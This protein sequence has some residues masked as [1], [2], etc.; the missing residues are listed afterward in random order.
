VIQR[1]GKDLTYKEYKLITP[2]SSTV[3]VREK[4]VN[5]EPVK[6]A[7]ETS[8]YKPETFPVNP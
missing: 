1:F 6:V 3:S 5:L 4:G 2:K 7:V 8:F